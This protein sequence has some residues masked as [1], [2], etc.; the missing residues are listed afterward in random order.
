MQL[1]HR[2]RC[3][4]PGGFVSTVAGDGNVALFAMPPTVDA[5]AAT[6]APLAFP[7]GLA[8]DPASGVLFISEQ[9]EGRGRIRTVHPAT[10]VIGSLGVTM[11]SPSGL[12]FDRAGFLLVAATARR[13]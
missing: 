6:S 9:T 4:S 7:S 10:G 11:Q 1:N 13:A 2:V 12:A 8:L 3:V 5:V